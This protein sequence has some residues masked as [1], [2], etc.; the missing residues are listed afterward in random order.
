MQ[1]AACLTALSALTASLLSAVDPVSCLIRGLLGYVIARIL[2]GFWCALFVSPSVETS[3]DV[4]DE[5]PVPDPVEPV[6]EAA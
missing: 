6:E 4:Q 1:L 3:G 5:A 2:A